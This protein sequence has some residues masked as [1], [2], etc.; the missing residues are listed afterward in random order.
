MQLPSVHDIIKKYRLTPH[1]EGG[2]F[3]EDFKSEIILP[4]SVT[5]RGARSIITTC[6]YLIPRGERSIFHRLR[7]D[8][9]WNHLLGGP[10]N[11]YEISP[12]GHLSE[13]LIG[14][15]IHK[16]Q[17]I[18]H[19]VKRGNWFGVLPQPETEYAL[20]SAIVFPGFE[21]E[22]WEKGDREYLKK[23]CPSAARIIELLT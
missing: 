9:I 23:L 22:D 10:V 1:I 20:F 12:N 3:S 13:V 7:S 5:G 4:P 14:P 16:N 6:Y 2:Y 17:N 8:E 19:L 18:K 11:C 21:Y 15:E